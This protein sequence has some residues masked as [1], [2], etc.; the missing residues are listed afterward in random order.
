[1][2]TLIIPDIHLDLFFAEECLQKHAASCDRIVLLGDYFDADNATL[3]ST[4]ATA[5]WVREKLHDSRF[6]CLLGNHDAQYWFNLRDLNCADLN[7][8]Y[9][10]A[11]QSVLGDCWQRFGLWTLQD[12]WLL[13]HAGVHRSFFREMTQ[14]WEQHLETMTATALRM[15]TEEKKVHRFLGCGYARWGMFSVGGV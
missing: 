14:P 6:T 15:A 5:Q 13:S 10:K 11:I 9:R 1:M 8:E 12:G 3:E 2:K 7:E 4:V